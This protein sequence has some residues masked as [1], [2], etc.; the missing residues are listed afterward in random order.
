MNVQFGVIQ[1]IFVVGA[2]IRNKSYEVC[3]RKCR[4]WFPGVS[5]PSSAEQVSSNTLFVKGEVAVI[6]VYSFRRNTG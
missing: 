6:P 2:C 4:N 3:C 5:V 1:R